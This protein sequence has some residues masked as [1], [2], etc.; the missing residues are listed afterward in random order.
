MLYTV[1]I[2]FSKEPEPVKFKVLAD[3]STGALISV[4][5]FDWPL[6]QRKR[7]LGA[8]V[9]PYVKGAAI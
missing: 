4:L 9:D 5:A 1:T 8:R 7:F 6:E 2:Y 3:T